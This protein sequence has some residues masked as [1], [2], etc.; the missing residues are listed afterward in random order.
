MILI[1]FFFLPSLLSCNS[2]PL[3]PLTPSELSIIQ[4]TIK[5]SNGLNSSTPLNFHYVGLAKPDKSALLSWHADDSHSPPP[6]R[7]AFVILRF[8]RGQT[9]EIYVDISTKSIVS[10]KIYTGF[11]YPT[12]NLEEQTRAST[13]PLKYSPF[14]ES[15]KKRGMKLSDVVCLAASVGW[16]GEVLKTKRVVK[17]ICYVTGDTVNFY[18]RPLEGITIVVDL[19]VMKIVDYKDRFVVPVPKAKG[20]DY[21]SAK[22]SLP[23]GRQGKPVTVVQPEGKG[24]VIDGHFISWANW[25][26]H[27]GYDVRAGAIISLAS[28]RE[29]EK[30]LYRQVLYKGFLSE[31]FVPYQDPTEDWYYRTYFDTGEY[32][33]GLYASSLQPLTDCPTN[34]EF[35]DGYYANQDGTPVKIKNV[36]C[37]FERYSGDSSWRHTETGIPGQ[38]C[39]NYDYITNWEFKTSGSI[40]VLVSLTGILAVK[41]TTYTNAG[42]VKK[43]E[44]LY[45][46]LLAENTIG[47]YHDHFLTYYLD[48]DIDGNKNSFV[49]AKIKTM[50]VTDGSSPRKSHWTVVK[51]TAETEAD[52]RVELGSEPANLL[53]VNTNKKTKV[54]NDVGYQIISH[55][56]TAASLLSDDDYP[57]IRAS[58]SKK[59]VWVTA[60]NKSEQ[61]AAGL[62]VD[63]SRG[64]DNL[65]VWS[66]RNRLIKNADI[67]VWYTVGFHHIPYQEDFPLMPIL[68]GG[69]ELR[70]SNF[71]ES[72]PLIKTRPFKQTNWPNCTH[73]S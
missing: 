44:D 39:G 10:N 14:M 55:G 19:D 58:Y 35:M 47:V 8:G 21:R 29:V 2:H 61:W 64:D 59:Q 48:L 24:F 70:P 33:F 37:V 31:L 50:R 18:M 3:D 63:Q 66:Q 43:D 15:V 69:F 12:F 65:A 30:G 26:F 25:R 36:L 27:L 22:Q 68:T 60:Y 32:G 38:V 53:V 28:V 9:H 42:Q 72:N 13:L 1:L 40:K 45:G 4:Q 52:G 17:L 5:T 49:Q 16:F 51:E 23:Y 11:G 56:A 46:T 57:Q 34:A 71:F 41:G 62:Y 67:V 54:G 6:P 73:R 20:T 7:M